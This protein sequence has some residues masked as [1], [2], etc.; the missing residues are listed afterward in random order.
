MHIYI[1]SSERKCN[2]IPNINSYYSRGMMYDVTIKLILNA[3]Q[4]PYPILCHPPT[5]GSLAHTEQVCYVPRSVPQMEVSF[6]NI[7]GQKV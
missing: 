7:G 3:V 4:L 1:Y 5:N 2:T 6:D